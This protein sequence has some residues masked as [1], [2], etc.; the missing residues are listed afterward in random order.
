MKI[1]DIIAINKFNSENHLY[2]SVVKGKDGVEHLDTIRDSWCNQLSMWLGLS[3]ASM[4]NLIRYVNDNHLLDQPQ[5]EVNLEILKRKINSYQNKTSC[6]FFS[7]ICQKICWVF[8]CLFCC[9]SKDKIEP[10]PTW[11][12]A[13]SDLEAPTPLVPARG[14]E[15]APTPLVSA[16]DSPVLTAQQIAKIFQ[17]KFPPLF[18][19]ADSFDVECAKLQT[20]LSAE[21]SRL[22]SSSGADLIYICM[23]HGD[24]GEQIWPG[25]ILEQLQNGKTVHSLLFERGNPYPFHLACNSF[26]EAYKSYPNAKLKVNEHLDKCFSVNQFLCGIPLPDARTYEEIPDTEKEILKFNDY[27]KTKKQRQEV[28]ESFQRYIE[29][30]LSQGKQIVLGDHMGSIRSP[31]YLVS[32]YNTLLEKY[33]KQ[34]HFLWGWS[35]LNVMTNHPIQEKDTSVEAVNTSGTIWTQYSRD[36]GGL[37]HCRLMNPSE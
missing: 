21:I 20:F 25:F 2:L 30:L 11:L 26:T 6:C 4:H 37:Y 18:S 29:I 3:P 22:E 17:S 7:V 8:S 28:Y 10:G 27:W 23:G 15:P 1:K 5:F 13:A 32:V 16:S 34:L 12:V 35:N 24:I 33:P 19:K 31:N 9:K 36:P 14:L